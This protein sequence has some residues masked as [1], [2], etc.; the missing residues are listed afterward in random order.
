[1]NSNK[2]LKLGTKTNEERRWGE[3]VL[4]YLSRWHWNFSS[5]VI[6]FYCYRH[7]RK[8]D[9]LNVIQ[10]ACGTLLAHFRNDQTLT[11]SLLLQS[12]DCLQ[13]SL[14]VS[15]KVWT[16]SSSCSTF[17]HDFNTLFFLYLLAYLWMMT[18]VEEKWL[19]VL[20]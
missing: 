4:F 19:C 12:R 15:P 20:S 11:L 18:T 5:F 3:K 8:I 1:M 2:A 17:Q 9:I 7:H 6:Y 10:V 16:Q 14:A 13:A